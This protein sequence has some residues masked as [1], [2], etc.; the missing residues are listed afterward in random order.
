MSHVLQIIHAMPFHYRG[1]KFRRF[2]IKRFIADFHISTRIWTEQHHLFSLTYVK[3]RVESFEI[4]F[5]DAG[6]CADCKKVDFVEI[7]TE[8]VIFDT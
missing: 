7:F 3:T 5:E 1:S 4:G 2:N 8:K 6:G